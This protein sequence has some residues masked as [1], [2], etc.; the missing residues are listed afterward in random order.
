MPFDPREVRSATKWAYPG[1]CFRIHA[2]LEAVED[3]LADLAAGF[4]RLRTQA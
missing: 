3:L 2:G 4:E 1:P